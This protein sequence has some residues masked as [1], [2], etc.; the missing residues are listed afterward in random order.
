[1]LMQPLR[2]RLPVSLRCMKT[3][4]DGRWPVS[5]LPR[6]RRLV[7]NQRPSMTGSR[8]TT[9]ATLCRQ[10]TAACGRRWPVDALL[11]AAMAELR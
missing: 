5:A 7:I 8:P 11:R 6:A 2:T 1:M 10:S 9:S 3:P 4:A